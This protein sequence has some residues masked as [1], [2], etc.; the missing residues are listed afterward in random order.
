MTISPPQGPI[1]GVWTAALTPLETDGHVA[2]DLLAKHCRDL[3]SRGCAGI[4]LFGTTGEGQS[5]SVAERRDTLERLL[6]AGISPAQ[7]IVGT[8]SAALPDTADLTRHAAG[9]G[10]AGALVLPPFFWRDATEDGVYVAYTKLI[11]L[12][13]DVKTRMFLYH[14]PQ[15]AGVAVPP[16]VVGRL[17]A[18]YPGLVAGVKDSSGNWENTMALLKLGAGLSILVGHEPY[19]PRALKA[20]AVGTICGLGNYRPELI[21]SLHDSAGKPEEVRLVAVVNKLVDLVTGVPFVPAIKALMAAETGEARWLNVRAPLLQPV[22]AESRRLLAV[23][24]SFDAQ[25]KAAA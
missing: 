19:L 7:V 16:A 5:F 6:A 11:E 8:G 15:V 23:A 4:T 3:L 1:R 17:A 22:E 18:A 20:G 14:I 21:R 10:V 2:H 24:R 12:L 9:L 13:G 25:A